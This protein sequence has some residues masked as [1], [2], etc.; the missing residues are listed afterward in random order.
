[1]PRLPAKS[2]A[3]RK[4]I[5]WAEL[6]AA[7]QWTYERLRELW[8]ALEPRERDEVRRLLERSKGR[9]SNLTKDEQRR[10]RIL[11]LKA[12]RKRGRR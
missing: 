9:P 4:T 7:A 3:A 2:T 12:W 6:L 10:L 11:V 8:D 1:M 5:R